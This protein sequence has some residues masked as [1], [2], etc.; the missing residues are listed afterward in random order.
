MPQYNYETGQMEETDE[1][2]R[3][4]EEAE[5]R[6][7]T[8]VV[9][10]TKV[11][12]YQD[13]SQTE[14]ITKEIPA[15]GF[16]GGNQGG[17]AIHNYLNITPQGPAAAPT[18]VTPQGFQGQTD[19]FGGVDEAVARQKAMAQPAPQPAPVAPGAPSSTFDR[20]IQVESGGRQTNAQGQ[21]LTSP[22]GAMGIAQVM[23]TTAMDP[24]YGVKNI[25]D[26]AQERGIPFQNRDRATAEQLLG[27][28]ALNQEFGANYYAAMNK[29]FDGGPGAVAAY[30]AGPGRVSQN[31]ARNQGQLN[32]AQLPQ[33]TQ[34]YLQKVGMPGPGGAA[35]GA[36]P[37]AST[38]QG[39]TNEFG[40]MEE[41][42]KPQP[43]SPYSLATGQDN[44]GI[45]MPGAAPAPAANTTEQA[46]SRYQ[47]IQDKP[48]ELMKFAFD[49]N[50][51]EYLK[52]RAKDQLVQ[53]YDNQKKESEAKK[54]EATATPKDIARAIT[55]KKEGNS[56]GDWFQYLLLKHVGL[57]DL[58]NQKGEQLGIGHKWTQSTIPDADGTDI[59]IELQ[60]TASGRVL[61]G[62]RLDGTP[63]TAKELN[64]AGGAI[65]SKLNI[66]GGTYVNDKTGEVGRVISNEKTGKS[67]IQTDTGRKPMTGFRPQAS[68]GSLEQQGV[69]QLQKLRNDLQFKGPEAAAKA[70]GEFDAM[71]GTR[72]LDQY[73]QNAPQ[74]FQSIGMTPPGQQAAG[75][76]T[77]GGAPA[78]AAGTTTPVPITTGTPADITS[79]RKVSEAE[80]LQFKEKVLPEINK[81]GDDG[82]FVA[83]TR[84]T[85][86][87]MLTGP[88]S[89]I[90]GI[91]RGTGDS[92][93]KA[94]AVLRDAI[95]GAYSGGEGG[96]RFSEAIRGISIPDEQLSALKE[97]AQLNTGINAK[98][99]A[100]NAG[101]GP[102][103][104]ADIK[105][106]Q[107]ANMTN[108]GDLPAF[109]ALSGL[110]RS[111][112]AGDINKRK[113]D[114]V[115]AN[116]DRYQTQSQVEK[117]WSKEKD[118]LN[119]QY[120]G[121]Y[122]ER[123]NFIDA[124]MVEKFGKDWRKRPSDET[125]GFYRDASIHSF[126]VLPT[127]NY[128]VQ[129]QK[130]V[131][132]TQQSKLAAMRAI[133]GR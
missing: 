30:N 24:G 21:V 4:R 106:N 48:D 31:M 7:G 83:D 105:L 78:Q 131:Y 119:R 17:G 69:T 89:A 81:K 104:D 103:S 42:P 75:T 120:E 60:T 71:N 128:D 74:F 5:K 59:A 73:K 35:S 98:T 107:Q 72:Y 91:Y 32:V 124:K 18:P 118:T 85:Q 2:R 117:A 127:P 57:T 49:E 109:A 44:Q 102:K 129:T 77:G 68:G 133:T 84:R 132:P 28:K 55:N 99:L 52:K 101:E 16:G 79:G 63:L 58:A 26:L 12:Q 66:V 94:R 41:M 1:E 95:S 70:L 96:E 110:T 10:E 27:N 82:R 54:M 130:F 80:R 97:F 90:M 3:A 53:S 34:G 19:E 112:F 125:Q 76:A 20:M 45:R 11:K 64:A 29:R 114:F 116:E 37:A 50:V 62:N 43:V 108:I 13:G 61:S 65:G 56:V 113:Q 123:L 111:Q 93:T 22:K 14:V 67:Y 88:N 9:G 33:E 36:A 92:Y 100:E 87:S 122:R 6:A 39:Q 46:I 38:F 115:L 15:P 51:P 8:T 121:I 47:A 86:V 25:F 126:N 23:P 40:G